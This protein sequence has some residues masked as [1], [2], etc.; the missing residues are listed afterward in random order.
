MNKEYIQK[1]ILWK[2]KRKKECYKI[3]SSEVVKIYNNV[4]NILNSYSTSYTKEKELDK[5]MLNQSG[6]VTGM[7]SK[8]VAYAVQTFILE[9]D[10]TYDFKTNKILCIDYANFEL[11]DVTEKIPLDLKEIKDELINAKREDDLEL[12]NISLDGIILQ[13]NIQTEVDRISAKYEDK[14]DEL[15]VEGNVND[16]ISSSDNLKSNIRISDVEIAEILSEL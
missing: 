1:Y 2:N 15:E 5:C 13:D 14:N 16:C 8:T 10:L 9:H 6:E 12:N 3:R 11:V 7:N 4:E